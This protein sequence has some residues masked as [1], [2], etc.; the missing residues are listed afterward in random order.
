M[1]SIISQYKENQV[2]AIISNRDSKLFDVSFRS[3]DTITVG[4]KIREGSIQ[5]IQAFSGVVIATSKS[6]NDFSYS[7]TVRKVSG[8]IGVER[9]F[10][11]YSPLIDS[12]KVDKRGVVR[13][14]KLYYLRN[15]K[16]RAAKIKERIFVK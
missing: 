6:T 15:L 5:R 1:S 14:A 4:C 16:G 2:N 12:I 8:G 7:F 3:G 10:F 13:R 11:L 9:K